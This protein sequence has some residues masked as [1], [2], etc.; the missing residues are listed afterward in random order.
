MQQPTSEE[1]AIV[2]RSVWMRWEEDHPPPLD[3]ILQT[4]D[5]AFEKTQRAD[6]MLL[7]TWGIFYMDD[8]I[9]DCL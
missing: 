9:P 2:K 5:T 7:Q 6:F 8:E 1:G 4:V 3:F